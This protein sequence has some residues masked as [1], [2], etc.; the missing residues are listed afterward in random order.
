MTIKKWKDIKE[1][2]TDALL[3]GN[4]A[5]IEFDKKFTY[6]SLW[7]AAKDT[8]Q[9][10]D[11][12]DNLAKALHTGTNFE[13][14]MNKLF[15]VI[16]VNNKFDIKS[17]EI[18]NTYK[19]IRKALINTVRENHCEYDDVKDRFNEQIPFLKNFNTIFSLN[20]DLLLYWIRIAS[21]NKTKKDQF[22]DCF[23]YIGFYD[24]WL[25]NYWEINSDNQYTCVFYP[26]GALHLARDKQGTDKKIFAEG[27]DLLKTIIH[28]WSNNES[29][30]L[31]VS[32]GNSKN[33]MASI[34][35]SD[36]LLKVYNEILPKSGPTLVIYG[37]SMDE[38]VDGHILNQII[39]GNYKKI[40]VHV[41]RPTTEDI[42]QF[43]NDTNEKLKNNFNEITYFELD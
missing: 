11:K 1:D 27:V 35:R 36:Y 16:N 12:I 32:E 29:L 9:I 8:D 13:L 43:I 3:M 24:E 15:E 21:N 17:D 25:R 4:G 20:Y 22:Y 5:S 31:F 18:I 39:G 28:Q 2:F 42:D 33:K 37:W 40:A 38:K 34:K 41:H 6:K 26:H 10:T 19:S 14:L 7:E 30:P 23:S